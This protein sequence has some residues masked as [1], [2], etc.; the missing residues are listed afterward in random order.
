MCHHCHEIYDRRRRYPPPGDY[1]TAVL[2]FEQARLETIINRISR[3][4]LK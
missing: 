1:M 3:G 2:K 4:I